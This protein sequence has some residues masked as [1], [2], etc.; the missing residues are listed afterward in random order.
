MRAKRGKARMHT[1][2]QRRANTWQAKGFVITY[3]ICTYTYV[4]IHIHTY[5]HTLHYNTIQ[6]NTIQYIHTYIH[7]YTHTACAHTHINTRVHA[8]MHACM[9]TCRMLNARCSLNSRRPGYPRLNVW[10]CLSLNFRLEG[11]FTCKVE[12]DVRSPGV[13]SGSYRHSARLAPM[14]SLSHYGFARLSVINH[15]FTP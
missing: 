7:T 2:T 15:A 3:I 5:I 14:S 12:T 6:Y 9:H 1:H 10:V 11:V 8:C 13:Q 4:Y